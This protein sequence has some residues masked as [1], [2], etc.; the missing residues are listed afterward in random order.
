V[1]AAGF[2]FLGLLLH[3]LVE[4][5]ALARRRQ[6]L[7]RITWEEGYTNPL[8]AEFETPRL[9]PAENTPTRA[10]RI[11]SEFP[12]MNAGAPAVVLLED[13]GLPT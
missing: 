7:T 13:I 9:K 3:A 6:E 8:A 1:K 12:R 4:S 5:C 11:E 2:H 10:A